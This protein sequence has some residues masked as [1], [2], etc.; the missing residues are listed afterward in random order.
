TFANKEV[1]IYL[2]RKPYIPPR[3]SRPACRAGYQ[4]LYLCRERHPPELSPSLK[5]DDLPAT[6]MPMFCSKDIK[7][8]PPTA[9]PRKRLEYPEDWENYHSALRMYKS[10]IRRAKKTTWKAY[11]AAAW[12][13]NTHSPAGQDS[14]ARHASSVD[15]P[16][17]VV[18]DHRPCD[19]KLFPAEGLQDRHPWPETTFRWMSGVNRR[20]QGIHCFT[21]GSLF[22]GAPLERRHYIV[23]KR[24]PSHL[25]PSVA[26][27]EARRRS[28]HGI[29]VTFLPFT[30]KKARRHKYLGAPPAV[31]VTT[32]TTADNMPRPPR[33]RPRYSGPMTIHSKFIVKKSTNLIKP[34]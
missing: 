9:T 17:Y 21:D 22:N 11:C 13:G 23:A 6:I 29:T 24:L 10:A 25:Y 19:H 33:L 12:K 3:G 27:G 14:Q 28:H 7:K 20:S 26:I 8:H 15:E 18:D 30:F 2:I 1:D 34:I 31:M 32:L 4:V 16:E 5:N